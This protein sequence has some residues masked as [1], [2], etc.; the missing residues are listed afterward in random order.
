MGSL[1]LLTLV[2][3]ILE[4]WGPAMPWDFTLEHLWDPEKVSQH[5]NQGWWGL[6]RL[7]EVRLIWGLACAY[8]ALYNTILE[9]ESFRAEVQA[10]GGNLQVKPDQSQQTPVTVSVAPVEGKKWKRV[11]SHLEQKK[12][13]SGGGGRGRSRQGDF[14]RTKKGKSKNQEA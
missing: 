2:G 5:L 8:C 12:K 6:D 11:S 7:K 13:R 10:K 14:L 9:R 4:V 3:R 1:K